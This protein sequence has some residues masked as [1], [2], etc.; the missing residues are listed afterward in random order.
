MVDTKY[1]NRDVQSVGAVAFGI[2]LSLDGQTVFVAGIPSSVTAYDVSSGKLKAEINCWPLP[3]R[4]LCPVSGGVLILTNK[5][6]VELWSG[7]LAERIKRWTNL[8]GVK[9]LIPIS[10]ERVAVVGEVD[11]KVLDTSSGKV[12]STIPVLQGRV[13]TC[14]SKCQL[15]IERTFEAYRFLR[16]GPWS[17]QLLD[18]ETVVWRKKDIE[19]IPE[20]YDKAAAFSPMEQFLVVGTIY[21]ILV[22]DPETGN[23]LRT[24]GFSFS[25]LHL[26]TFISGDTCVI[27]GFDSPVWLLN[28]KSGELL[29]EID[30]EGRLLCLAACPFNRVLAIGLEDSTPN[31][32]VIRVHLPRGEDRGNMER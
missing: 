30:V 15:L 27:S 5:T 21:G 4:P 2:A 6:T 18:G 31:F 12:V 23:T 19:G 29:T 22:L 10:E 25:L 32:K 20:Y 8:P 17:L 16:S 13:L 1:V 7:N 26:C 14:N 11:V 3:Y 24:L 28:V 9:Q